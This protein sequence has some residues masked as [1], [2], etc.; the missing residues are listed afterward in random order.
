MDKYTHWDIFGWVTD[1]VIHHNWHRFLLGFCFNAFGCSNWCFAGK[2]CSSLNACNRSGILRLSRLPWTMKCNANEDNKSNDIS[3]TDENIRKT[4][5]N[6]ED[7]SRSAWNVKRYN[8]VN[9][10]TCFLNQPFPFI[11]DVSLQL[12]TSGKTC[13][14][15]PCQSQVLFEYN[16]I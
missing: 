10:I 11:S 9:L 5:V 3:H 13:I 4:P 15:L 2:S 14:Y 16:S 7:H 8:K 1:Y 12:S 6:S